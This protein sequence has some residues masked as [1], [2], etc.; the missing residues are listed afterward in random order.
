MN[1]ETVENGRDRSHNL[2]EDLG[3]RGEAKAESPKLVRLAEGHKPQVL[4]T[5]QVD[6][7]LQVCFPQIDG[8][9]PVAL[10]D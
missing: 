4:V 2:G 6:G 10:T 3:S 8:D 7:D 1:A 5:V 9:H